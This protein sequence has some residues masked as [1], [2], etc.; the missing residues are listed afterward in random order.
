[1]A[2]KTGWHLVA[3]PALGGQTRFS[4]HPADLII[5]QILMV[6]DLL[7]GKHSCKF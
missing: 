7:L 3:R 6:F 2:I 1:V 5:F 4:R